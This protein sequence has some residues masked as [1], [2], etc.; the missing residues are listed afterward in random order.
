MRIVIVASSIIPGNSSGIEHFTYGLLNSLLEIS[1][2]DTFYVLI[3]NGTTDQWTQRVSP[4]ANLILTPMS[5]SP[6]AFSLTASTS[7]GLLAKLYAWLKNRALARKVFQYIRRLELELRLRIIQP[8]IVYSSYHLETL[9]SA[10]WKT[11]IT[12][13]D[14][15]EAMREFYDAEKASILLRNLK[16]ARAVIV[17]WKH[18]FHQLTKMFPEM[19]GKVCLIPFPIPMTPQG[20]KFETTG[21][22]EILLFASALRPQKNHI[23]LIRALGMVVNQR[24]KNGRS[25]RLVC[26]GATH[27]PTYQELLREVRD[28]GLQEH[29][30]FTGFISD[31]AL[32]N[33]YG[34]TTVV[35]TPTLWEAASGAVFEAFLFEKPVACSQIPPII[36]QVEQ[37]GGFVNYFDPHDPQDIARSILEVLE[38][39]APYIEGAKNGARFV[40]A[41]SWEKTASEYIQVFRQIAQAT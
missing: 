31:E 32:K 1:T 6:R 30:E 29:V 19:S 2:T 24:K 36:A 11:L 22:P 38:D 13:H 23:N 4:R 17:A 35:V 8:D 10:K 3:P 18:P 34:K 39:P 12:V 7:A 15:R 26:A 33:L 27:S 41:L 28:L 21:T 25:V 20:S 16:M 5:L 40:R 14:L 9:G 37:S